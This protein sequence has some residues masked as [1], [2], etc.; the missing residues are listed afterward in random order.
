MLVEP[1]TGCIM[2]FLFVLIKFSS[3]PQVAHGVENTKF[4]PG[5]FV[6]VSHN[7]S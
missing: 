2:Q 4:L 3:F 1:S 7:E 6:N 5:V